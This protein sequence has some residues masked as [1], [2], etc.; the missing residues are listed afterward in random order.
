MSLGNSPLTR[1]MLKVRHILGGDSKI[2]YFSEV[3]VYKIA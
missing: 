2:L 3:S 1:S